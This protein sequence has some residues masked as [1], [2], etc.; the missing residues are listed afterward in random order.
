MKSRK[1]AGKL[2]VGL[3]AVSMTGSVIPIYAAGFEQAVESEFAD[4]EMQYRPY[5]RWWLA[6]GSHTDETLKE[7]IQELYEDGYGGVEFVTLN[8]SQFLSNEDY[9]W[10]SPEWIHDTK[11]II[12]ECQ[13]RGMSVSMT[14]GTHWSTANLVS[15]TPDEEAA[16][17]E[18]GYT[19]IHLKGSEDETKLTSYEGELKL[20][21]LPG[22]VSKQRLVGVTAVKVTERGNYDEDTG[23]FAGTRLSL[24]SS[25]DVTG[26]VT[27]QDGSYRISY[28]APDNGDYELLAFYQ[29]GTGESSSPA[30]S[31][32]YTINYLN[33]A[34][35][36]ALIDY[37]DSSVLT[38][39]VKSLIQR[40]EEC[41]LYMDSL[42]LQAHGINTTG[43]LWCSDML[44]Q[45]ENRR[46]YSMASLL[47]FVI[48]KSARSG[49]FGEPVETVYKADNEEDQVYVQNLLNDLFQT[50]TEQYTE[51]CLQIL[52]NWLHE[53]NMK[54]RA[55]NSYGRTFE[56]SEP[57]VALDYIETESMEFA[58][59]IDSHR[60]MAG[61]VHLLDKRMSSETGAWVSSNYVYN[62]AYYRQIFYMQYAAG[63]QKVITHGYSSEYGPEGRVQWPG[64]EGMDD[65]WSDRFSK[66]QPAAVDYPELNAHLSRIQKLLEEGVPQMDLAIMRTDYAFNNQLTPGGL[67]NF[68]NKGVYSNKSHNQ[69]AYYWRDMELQNAG[70]TYDYFS[71]Y[72]LNEQ[73]V[74]C[75]DG[76]INADG[77]AYQA[78]I[79]MEEE[80]PLESAKTI[81]SWAQNGLPVLFVNN[82]EELIANEN[83]M[84]INEN[85][86]SKTGSNTSD[87]EELAVVVE[88]IK[89]LKNVR[90]VES[91][92]D[93]YEALQELEIQPRV[94]YTESNTRILPVLRSTEE[95]DY[96]YLYHY[97]YEDEKN[98]QG[99]ISLDGSFIPYVLN[100]WDGSAEE[101]KN[102]TVKDGR[103]VIN[104]DAAP[105]EVLTYVLQKNENA[106]GTL[107]ENNYRTDGRTEKESM[108]LSG[109]DLTVDSYEEGERVTRTETNEET[110]LTTTE[111]AYATK[112]VKKEAGIQET[113]YPWKELESIGDDV[114]GIGTYTT[115]FTIPESWISEDSRIEFQ[116]EGFCG[117]TVSVNVNGKK[118]PVNMD[119]CS[120]D[121]TTYVTA[122]EN[123]IK[124]DVT[125]SLRN[126]MIRKGYD[127]GW[128]MNDPEPDSY[129]M[130]GSTV[131]I[132]YSR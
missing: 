98:Y 95:A 96:L 106:A 74:S 125:S 122:G 113:L 55:E 116:A 17:Q 43:L 27:D 111:V 91:E 72:L 108:E 28:T 103:T 94:K 124:V 21:E 39:E 59:E 67:L 51:N 42:E 100:T 85:A 40:I 82:T 54:L 31:P 65:V 80:L 49:A 47:P 115:A 118:V 37:W 132:L 114:S 48:L 88:Q 76:M 121:I 13:K 16:S 84:K 38:E 3:L 131:L 20:C 129:G 10:G 61:A 58:N 29:Y 56:I 77:V 22:N 63:I 44:E 60:N 24:T 102:Y 36:N 25:Q 12:E 99:Q 120:A 52:A 75:S 109:W 93:A 87:D 119:R 69:D 8:E 9:A 46:G 34:G 23:N 123:S 107:E 11:I 6:E 117:G 18:L 66:R 90:T 101:A 128:I 112:H 78:L 14:S 41:D 7:S 92:A 105:G 68:V 15:I 1:T 19:A 126:V 2:L 62:N 79:L 53:N 26:L 110:G 64:Y 73:N 83:V 127:S 130:T 71:P 70:Y 33:E 57:A 81:L 89:A 4:P 35:A 97:M 104:I 5:A 45:F 50:Q 32:S 86:A 30:I